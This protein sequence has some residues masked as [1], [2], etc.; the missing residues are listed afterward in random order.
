MLVESQWNSHVNDFR[1]TMEDNNTSLGKGC[2]LSMYPVQ[3]LRNT[4]EC[5][6]CMGIFASSFAHPAFRDRFISFEGIPRWVVLRYPSSYSE[7]Q[8]KP[9]YSLDTLG[10]WDPSRAGG[11]LSLYEKVMVACNSPWSDEFCSST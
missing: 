10:K 5:R 2:V 3:W 11:E 7:Y 1:Q 9:E 6:N 8:N 4:Y